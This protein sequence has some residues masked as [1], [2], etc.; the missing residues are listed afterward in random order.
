MTPSPFVFSIRPVFVDAFCS[1]AKRFELRTRRPSVYRGD[2]VL[3]YETAPTSMIVAEATVGEIRDA[4]PAEIWRDL[5]ESLGVTREQFDAY[6]DG[7]ARAVAIELSCAWLDEPVPLPD[8]MAAPQSWS[9]L[10]G[11]WTP[12]RA[13]DRA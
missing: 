5:H 9:R 7:R 2:L 10:R 12:R 6:F 11:E 13:V 4:S 8:G 1:G 3:I